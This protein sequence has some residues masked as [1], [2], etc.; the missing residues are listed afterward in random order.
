MKGEERK[1]MS[2]SFIPFSCAH[3]RA[4]E[5]D[6]SHFDDIPI[7]SGALPPSFLLDQALALLEAGESPLWHSPYAFV[8]AELQRVVGSGGFKGA[9]ANGRVEIGYGV[10]GSLQGRGYATAAVTHLLAIAFLDPAVSE[11][12]AET[13]V[14]NHASRRVIQKAGFCHVGQRYTK[15]DGAVDQWILCGKAQS[16]I[17]KGTDV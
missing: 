14:E 4:L 7:V 11:V 13:V 9:P 5:A 8:D 15:E 16:S 1:L 3:L 12:Y 6:P 2:L 17:S 10:A